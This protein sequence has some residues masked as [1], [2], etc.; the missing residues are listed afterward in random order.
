MLSS[1]DYYNNIANEY[2]SQSSNRELYLSSINRLVINC[3]EERHLKNLLDVGAGDGCRISKIREHLPPFNL[4]LVEQS[5][6]LCQMA[7]NNLPEAETFQGDFTDLEIPRFYFSQITCLWNVLGHVRSVDDFLGKVFSCLNNDGVFIFDV[8]NRYNV[9]YYGFWSVFTNL[10]KDIL[11]FNKSG[12]FP[13]GKDENKSLVYI[14]SKAEILK[15]LKNNGFKIEKIVYVD[16]ANGSIV[17]N[18]WQGQIF[19]VAK[20][21]A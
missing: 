10:I 19:V 5:E 8:N 21:A 2:R 12:Y 20:K 17:S 1:K 14:F 3:L 15:L 13:I 9:R 6:E 16:Y 18:H 11:R 4:A 7:R